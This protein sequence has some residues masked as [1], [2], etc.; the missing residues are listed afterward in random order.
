MIDKLIGK[1]ILWTFGKKPIQRTTMDGEKIGKPIQNEIIT[2]D[3]EIK[4]FGGNKY[5]IKLTPTNQNSQQN[6]Q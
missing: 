4:Y 1:N 3:V 2:Y 6:S 5:S